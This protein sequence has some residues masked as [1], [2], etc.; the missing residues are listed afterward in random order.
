M[1]FMMLLLSGG[2]RVPVMMRDATGSIRSSLGAQSEASGDRVIT[3]ARKEE[4]N[5][6]P[7]PTPVLR[8]SVPWHWQAKDRLGSSDFSEISPRPRPGKEIQKSRRYGHSEGASQKASG[9]E[10]RQQIST[11]ID[12]K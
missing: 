6:P 7:R 11:S 8:V 4:R 5:A 9:C 12:C 10:K 2:C 3:A 1:P